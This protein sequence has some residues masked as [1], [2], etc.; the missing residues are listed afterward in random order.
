PTPLTPN[1]LSRLGVTRCAIRIEGTS[2]AVGNAYSSKDWVSRSA[3]ARPRCRARSRSLRCR[4][5]VGLAPTPP[6]AP[7]ELAGLDE[8]PATQLGGFPQGG[9]GSQSAAT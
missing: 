1:G 9:D 5:P 4:R 3:P 8:V 6:P 2:A 7:R